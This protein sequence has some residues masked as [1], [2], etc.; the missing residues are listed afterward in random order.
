MRRLALLMLLVVAGCRDHQSSAEVAAPPPS[1]V[2]GHR[3][4]GRVIDEANVLS[5]A[6][7]RQ[8]AQASEELERAT[9][10]QLVIVTVPTLGKESIEH[11][12][13]ALGNGW[14][15]GQKGLDNGVLILVA[16][17]DRKVRVE[18]GKGLEGLLTNT[19]A[20][21][22]VRAMLPDFA[23]RRP[24]KAIA[25]GETRIIQLLR[26]DPRRPQRKST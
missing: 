17:N 13:W 25:V 15:I 10:D 22:V 3:L 7:E 1:E 23:A 6:E 24:A 21:D 12:G 4:S 2:A 18:V 19:R 16:P 11:L 5:S 9:S 26:S 20:A 8:L 14:G